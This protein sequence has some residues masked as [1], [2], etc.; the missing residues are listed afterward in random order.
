MKYIFTYRLIAFIL[1]L[2][3]FSGC[4][5][6]ILNTDMLP[7][8]TGSPLR[9]LPSK[10]FAFNEFKDE[11]GTDKVISDWGPHKYRLDKS[12]S[13]VVAGAI[14]QEFERNGHQ[15]AISSPKSKSDFVVG[16][17]V[18]TYWLESITGRGLSADIISYVKIDVTVSTLSDNSNKEYT[19]TYVGEYRHESAKND[20][21]GNLFADIL[22]RT[23]GILVGEISTDSE[24]IAFIEN[25]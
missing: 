4:T 8:Q 7:L 20:Y 18:K 23:L 12:V 15:C 19:K 25:K 16:G 14:M 2:F 17:T 24:L 11:R 22:K 9:C 13:L 1:I 3:V 6:H 5:N 10:T 21:S